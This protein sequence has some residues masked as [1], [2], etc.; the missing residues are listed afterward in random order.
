M[1]PDC[2]WG[3][4]YYKPKW[5]CTHYT[6]L[7]LRNLEVEPS[8][9]PA[10]R[11]IDDA[12]KANIG[13]DGGINPSRSPRSASD[14]CIN[15]MF[16]RFACYFRQPESSLKSIIDF[17]LAAKMNDGGF[18]CQFKKAATKHGSLHTT[19]SVCEGLHE[20]I[21][22]GYGYRQ[23]EVGSALARAHDFMLL[24]RLYKSDRT[25]EIIDLKFLEMRNPTRWRYDILRALDHL[26]CAG[27]PYDVRME[28]AIQY[29]KGLMNERGR[30]KLGPRLPGERYF[31]MERQGSE[32]R[33]ITLKALRVLKAYGNE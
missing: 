29:I 4:E 3:D 21:R 10:R 33:W 9:P 7:E 12:I 1:N 25:G 11:A 14:V 6:L 32:S 26:R 18:N 22:S 8:L 5:K 27:A 28:D 15:G 23:N 24:H 13:R 20:Y 30:W 2:S 16:L 31:D 19:L 17:L